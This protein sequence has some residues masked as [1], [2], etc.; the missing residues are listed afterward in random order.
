M[1][2]TSGRTRLF[3]LVAATVA[4]AAGCY[5][6][7]DNSLTGA[8]RLELRLPETPD[9]PDSSRAILDSGGYVYIRAIGGPSGDVGPL[10]GPLAVSGKSLVISD[11]AP[12]VYSNIIVLHTILELEENTYSLYA[13]DGNPVGEYT[14]QQIM[15]FSDV[16]LNQYLVLRV[17]YDA[18]FEMILEGFGSAVLTGPVVIKP[19]VNSMALTLVPQC[20]SGFAVELPFSVDSY[21]V[22]FGAENLRFY[23]VSLDAAGPSW[24]SVY[25]TV[26]VD[27]SGS[28]N[29]FASNG[30]RIGGVNYSSS[31]STYG[32]TISRSS[33]PIYTYLT[34]GLEPSPVIAAY[35]GGLPPEIEVVGGSGPIS[36]GQPLSFGAVT[37]AMDILNQYIDISNDGT[38]P[39]VISSMA[40]T[41]ANPSS[42]SVSPAAPF[43]VPPKGERTITVTLHYT[44]PSGMKYA[45]LSLSTND[46]DENPF[47]INLSG[48][49]S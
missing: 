2:A 26:E 22:S 30:K 28:C 5:S 45:V 25:L 46:A 8:A 31:D 32:V 7:A 4:L 18:L 1:N 16:V 9:S 11:I 40:I 10:W 41:G 19:G 3:C 13:V 42:Y 12:G 27:G 36:S 20:P 39:L 48:D 49:V 38:Q 21:Q 14:F 29:L 24:P 6:P 15:A 43:T 44:P 35:E 34:D 37:V 33:F 47:V 23:E 17:D